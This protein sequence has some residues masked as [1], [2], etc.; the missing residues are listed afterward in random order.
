MDV[1]LWREG[2]GLGVRA[3]GRYVDLFREV[4]SRVDHKVIYLPYQAMG[5]SGLLD[6]LPS[7]Y[8]LS[9]KLSPPVAAPRSAS[10][11]QLPQ[12]RSP[13]AFDALS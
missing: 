2:C 7:V 6:K 1:P 4:M 11:K 12:S 8:G 3:F 10:L 9:A 13:T 5:I